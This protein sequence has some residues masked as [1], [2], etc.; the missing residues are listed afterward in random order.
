[1]AETATPALDRL[2]TAEQVAR[3][4]GVRPR[5]VLEWARD[6]VVPSVRLSPKCVRFDEALILDALRASGRM[7]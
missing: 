2:R 3:L 6:G 7:S 4:L 1:M 5:T